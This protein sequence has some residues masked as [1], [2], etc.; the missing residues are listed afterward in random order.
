MKYTRVTILMLV[1]VF[2]MTACSTSET[3]DNS[4]SFEWDTVIRNDLLSGETKLERMVAEKVEIQVTPSNGILDITISAPDICDELLAWMNAIDDADFTE[5]ALETEIIRLLDT[6]VPTITDFS[7]PYTQEESVAIEYSQD[8]TDVLS[9]GL[10][11]FN[12]EITQYIME[13]MVN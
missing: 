12:R 5:E 3:T 4:I 11:R 13:A 2:L 6:V 7:L 1:I 8:F 9:C 10:S